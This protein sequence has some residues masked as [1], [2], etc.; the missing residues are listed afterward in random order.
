MIS[1]SYKKYCCEDPSLIEN[2]D[3]AIADTAQTWEIH[4]RGEILPCGR[5]S[6]DDLKKF[7]LYY[8][9]PAAELIFL[10]PSEHQRLHLKGVPLSEATKKAISDGLKG[11]QK[12]ETHK[13]ALSY[14]LKGHSVSE[15]TKKAISKALKGHSVS[16]ATKKAISKARSKKVL[17][18]TKAGE[19]ISEWQ[20][21]MEASHWLGIAQPSICICCLGKRKSAGGFVWRYA[22][23][24]KKICD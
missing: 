2:Y 8:K 14:A 4:H 15:A 3:R 11:V 22:T 17:Q 18:L 1:E 9:R 13:K 7:G 24:A 6:R 12:R 23:N 21:A 10:T 5:F 19:F 20:S 16:E